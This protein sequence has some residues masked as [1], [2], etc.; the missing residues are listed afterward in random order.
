MPQPLIVSISP[1][2]RDRDSTARI[3]WTVVAVLAPVAAWSGYVFGYRAWMVILTAVVF[4]VGSE[5]A[6]CL[7]RRIPSTLNDG[8]AIIT[9]TLLAFCLPANVPLYV[10]AVGSVIAIVLVKSIFGGL[11]H[12]I[13]NPALMARAI[14]QLSFPTSLNLAQWPILRDTHKF[15]DLGRFAANINDVGVDAVTGATVTAAVA[16]PA[17]VADAISQATPLNTHMLPPHT[18]VLAG[19]DPS[20]LSMWLGLRPGCL[21]E[22]CFVLLTLGCLVLIALRIVKWYMPTLYIATTLL[23]V[24]VLPYSKGPLVT[25]WGDWG[26]P[27]YHL[28][29]GGVA[30]GAMF[31]ATDMVTSPLTAAG[32]IIFAVGCGLI[33]GLIR[34]YGGY[35]EGVCYAILLMNTATPLIDRIT[36]PR[37]FGTHR[38]P[39]QGVTS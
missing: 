13:W 10:P 18:G 20:H 26:Y 25:S 12:N 9:G 17:R 4:A 16:M 2:L 15:F 28:L 8:S 3:M 34:L 6:V 37:V 33:T 31:M 38:L 29:F 32:R 5:A 19:Y 21:G 23:V 27:A 14:L 11:G 24:T 36:R 22:T 7:Y 35:P 1:H 30:L 39:R